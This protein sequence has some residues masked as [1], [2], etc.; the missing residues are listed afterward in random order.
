MLGCSTDLLRMPKFDGFSALRVIGKHN[1]P[2][3]NIAKPLG[4]SYGHAKHIRNN[5]IIPVMMLSG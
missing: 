1:Q 4:P 3:N 2:G 5:E